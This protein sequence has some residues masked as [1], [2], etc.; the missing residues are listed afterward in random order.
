MLGIKCL[1]L[2]W[3]LQ[4]QG[5]VFDP[6]IIW[7][8]SF[9]FISLVLKVFPFKRIPDFSEIF[10]FNFF[11]EIFL[12]FPYTSLIFFKDFSLFL[13]YYSNLT[14]IK[15]RHLVVFLYSEFVSG[16]DVHNIDKE[17]KYFKIRKTKR[18]LITKYACQCFLLQRTKYNS[19]R[20]FPN[21]P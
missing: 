15:T 4:N 16:G 21:Q 20:H 18:H 11:L 6:L 2:Q 17:W 10:F 1:S 19:R 8:S 12:F 13:L 5:I 9:I 3:H 14:V 7:I